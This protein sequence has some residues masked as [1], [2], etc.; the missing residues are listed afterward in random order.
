MFYFLVLTLGVYFV[1]PVKFRNLVLLCSSLFFYY[2]GERE[3]VMIMFLSTVIDYTH[4][5]LVERFKAQGNI[6]G[7]KI[8]VGSSIFFRPSASRHPFWASICPSAS[9][10]TPSRP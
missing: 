8:A 2:W 4:G 3:Y 1:V 7:A 6:K 10:S 9:L 5:L